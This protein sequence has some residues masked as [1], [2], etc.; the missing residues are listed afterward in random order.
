VVLVVSWYLGL[1]SVVT[2]L[3]GVLRT[4]PRMHFYRQNPHYKHAL[5]LPNL[6]SIVGLYLS[7]ILVLVSIGIACSVFTGYFQQYPTVDSYKM[8]KIILA[9][10]FSTCSIGC[11]LVAIGFIVY[12][13]KLV[14]IAKEALKLLESVGGYGSHSTFVMGAEL[15]LKYKKL[16]RSIRKVCITIVDHANLLIVVYRLLTSILLSRFRCT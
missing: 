2:Y 5:H 10:H 9:I 13:N 1:V 8:I 11:L 4:I 12:G 3:A 15:E 14:K 6:C 7:Y 16:Q